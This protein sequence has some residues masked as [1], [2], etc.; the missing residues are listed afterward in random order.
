[1][2]SLGFDAVE[3]NEHKTTGIIRSPPQFV[4]SSVEHATKRKSLEALKD[5]SGLL[6]QC[7]SLIICMNIYVLCTR[8]NLAVRALL[9]I[10]RLTTSFSAGGFSH[11]SRAR[12]LTVC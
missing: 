11:P 12:A 7:V 9:F 8:K 3:L 6:H 2:H 10:I 1:M 5:Y 4:D